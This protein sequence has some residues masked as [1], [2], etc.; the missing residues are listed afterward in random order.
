MATLYVNILIDENNVN[1]YKNV[2]ILWD[3]FSLSLFALKYH[4]F[5][6]V[7]EQLTRVFLTFD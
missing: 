1:I 4:F 3:S 6:R 2:I 7:R 5:L